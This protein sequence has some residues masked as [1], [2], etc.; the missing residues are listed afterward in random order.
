MGWL[1]EQ[2]KWLGPTGIILV[3]GVGVM[4]WQRFYR[5][6]PVFV[7][8]ESPELV[9]DGATVHQFGDEL[10][11]TV[12]LHGRLSRK[13]V[14]GSCRLVTEGA[15]SNLNNLSS[16]PESPETEM[17]RGDAWPVGKPLSGKTELKLRFRIDKNWRRFPSAR[18][19][20]IAGNDE[21]WSNRID[22]Q[23]VWE[24]EANASP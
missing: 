1:Q 13:P 2:W 5:S 19:S 17:D 4:I 9:R 20:V 22:L 15:P 10:L 18:L 11:L 6:W 23:R 3:A 24:V 8:I 7:I 12:R 16:T 14:L 21:C